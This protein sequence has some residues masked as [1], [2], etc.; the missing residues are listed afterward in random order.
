MGLALPADLHTY[1]HNAWSTANNFGT[2]TH[3]GRYV[4]VRG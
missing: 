3:V 2:V 4:L 1:A